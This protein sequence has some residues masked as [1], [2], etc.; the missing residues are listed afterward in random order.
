MGRK[1][2]EQT[3]EQLN[4]LAEKL[5]T[6]VDA[7]DRHIKHLTVNARNWSKKFYAGLAKA[8]DAELVS[9]NQFAE[10]PAAEL[11][12]S[13]ADNNKLFDAQVALASSEEEKNRTLELLERVNASNVGLMKKLQVL[14]AEVTTAKL[15]QARLQERLA[16]ASQE[17]PV[18][19]HKEAEEAEN[20]STNDSNSGEL[21]FSPEMKKTLAKYAA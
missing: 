16:A 8:D 7:K 9:D 15:I 21:E 12:L 11:E 6:E 2:L 19:E 3:C 18:E 1:E 20:P 13:P 17:N 14:K 10:G 4:D 5:K